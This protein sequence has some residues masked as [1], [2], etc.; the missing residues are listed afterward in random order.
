MTN[1]ATPR[2]PRHP[3]DQQ[4]LAPSR[5]PC[6]ADS[7]RRGPDVS[8]QSCSSLPISTFP[9]RET[10]MHDT[11]QTWCTRRICSGRCRDGCG[12]WCTPSLHCTLAVSAKSL[13]D[14]P[15]SLHPSGPHIFSRKQCRI[16]LLRLTAARSA[17]ARLSADAAD[18]ACAIPCVSIQ[19]G[20]S[21]NPVAP[22]W[23]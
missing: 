19:D 6:R 20:Q 10:H 17:L 16:S 4:H 12:R 23:T 18:F 11:G 14:S 13:Q 5:P 21:S 22:S 9:R 2:L 7:R 1:S 15:I 3:P 8:R